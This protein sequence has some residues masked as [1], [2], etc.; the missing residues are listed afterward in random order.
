MRLCYEKPEISFDEF[1]ANEYIAACY[2]IE[3]N[4]PYGFGYIEK[5]GISGYQKRGDIKLAEGKGCGEVHKGVPGVPD[6]GPVANAMWQQ[7]NLWGK[8]Y[9]DPYPVFHWVDGEGSEG[10]HFS[11]VSDADWEENANAS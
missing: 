4:V 10:H 3:C 7:T 5:N 9:G 11:K 8:P 1:E 6:D 2:D